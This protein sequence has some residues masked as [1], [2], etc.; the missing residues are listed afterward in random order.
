MLV[1]NYFSQLE[2][3]IDS[4]GS[5]RSKIITKDRRSDYTGYFRADLYFHNGS[6]LHVREFVFTR[7]EVIKD[8]YVYHYQ[9]TAEELIFRYDNTRH[10]PDLPNFPHHKHT[11]TA[12]VSTTE[13]DLKHILDEVL[14][15]S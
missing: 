14:I 15:I 5:I 8:T 11:P 10:F 9:N 2:S 12:V 1:E 3:L 6:R 4:C 7:Q 13:P